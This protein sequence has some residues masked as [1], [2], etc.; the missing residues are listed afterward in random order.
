MKCHDN[1]RIKNIEIPSSSP[2]GLLVKFIKNTG[3]I[4]WSAINSSDLNFTPDESKEIRTTMLRIITC[5]SK[6][7]MKDW[8]FILHLDKLT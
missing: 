2:I 6:E 3:I 8:G 7:I 5:I 4:L 1:D